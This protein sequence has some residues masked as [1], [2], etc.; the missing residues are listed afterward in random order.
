M[1]NVSTLVM[2]DCPPK[3]YA[4][5]E[6]SN[7]AGRVSTRGRGYSVLLRRVLHRRMFHIRLWG[8]GVCTL[9]IGF[10]VGDGRSGTR[11]RGRDRSLVQPRASVDTWQT[12]ERALA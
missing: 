7:G 12:S 10:W 5:G 11:A 4:V 2:G 3:A 9:S 6:D 8:G 1:A